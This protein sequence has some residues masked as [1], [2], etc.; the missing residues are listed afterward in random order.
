MHL[1][2]VPPLAR[3]KNS[4]KQ[5][6]PN[7]TRLVQVEAQESASSRAKV[8]EHQKHSPK[9]HWPSLLALLLG[10]LPVQEKLALEHY[11]GGLSPKMVSSS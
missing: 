11:V 9:V 4:A 5:K 3:K 1:D 6:A 10:T 7:S 2:F 8:P